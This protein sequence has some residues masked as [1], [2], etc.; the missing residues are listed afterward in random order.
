[1]NETTVTLD[2]GGGGI[3]SIPSDGDYYFEGFDPDYVMEGR[4]SLD[5]IATMMGDTRFSPVNGMRIP[6]E[7]YFH[8]NDFGSNE[9]RVGISPFNE[10]NAYQTPNAWTYTWIGDQFTTMSAENEDNKV[11]ASQFTLY[12]NFP[13]PFNPTTSIQFS[14]DKDQLVSLNIYNLK[15]QL[16]ESLINKQLKLGLHSFVWDATD[17]ASGVYIYQLQSIDNSITKKMVLMK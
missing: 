7:V 17:F 15:G 10:D 2:M 6:V 13:N 3:L 16:V 5:S 4:I 14:L 1:M 11:S 12:P 9:G 8:D